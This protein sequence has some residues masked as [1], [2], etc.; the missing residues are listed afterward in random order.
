MFAS[1]NKRIDMIDLSNL[2]FSKLQALQQAKYSIQD[3]NY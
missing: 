3:V 2:M 1:F